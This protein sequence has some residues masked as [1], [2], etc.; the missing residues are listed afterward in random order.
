MSCMSRRY[1]FS[2]SFAILVFSCNAFG[3]SA[4]SIKYGLADT[5]LAFSL[6]LVL[7]E[8]T[9]DT[10]T[11]KATLTMV[12]EAVRSAET[13]VLEGEALKAKLRK[14]DV[15]VALYE[16]GTIK[17]IGSTTENRTA[18]VIGSI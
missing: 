14:R 16:N 3:Q 17:S 11:T 6:E 13:E 4:A 8:C 7:I 9:A 5:R 10:L 15:T 12:P 1:A 2:L 18:A